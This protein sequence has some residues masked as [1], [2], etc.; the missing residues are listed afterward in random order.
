[1]DKEQLKKLFIELIQN[2]EIGM[3]LNGYSTEYSHQLILSLN[4]DGEAFI[5]EEVHLDK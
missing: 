1:M 3:F 2:G 5:Q 4:I